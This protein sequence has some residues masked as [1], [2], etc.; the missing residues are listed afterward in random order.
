MA[1]LRGSSCELCGKGANVYC[2]ADNAFLCVGCDEKVHCVNF[3]VA[4]HVRVRVCPECCT[5]Y[6]GKSYSSVGG[7]LAALRNTKM[8]FESCS[9]SPQAEGNEDEFRD[10]YDCLSSSSSCVSST[11]GEETEAGVSSSSS[12]LS[13]RKRIKSVVVDVKAEGILVI[14]SRTFDVDESRVVRTAIS[15]LSTNKMMTLPF[16]VSLAAS[17]W[18]AMKLHTPRTATCH[19][20]RR[21]EQISGVPAKL[22]AAL[23]PRAARVNKRKQSREDH[24]EGWAEC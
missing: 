5:H 2:P 19:N 7:T 18:V 21:L 20:L 10:E 17:F 13:R 1:E 3:L 8:N 9:C 14:W 4:R 12:T 24:E 23:E 15:L 11:T 22:I 6:A 16:R